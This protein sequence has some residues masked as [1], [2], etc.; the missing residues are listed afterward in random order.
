MRDMLRM[1]ADAVL[2]GE[3]PAGEG[4]DGRKGASG[5]PGGR[6]PFAPRKGDGRDAT[7]AADW[8]Q[9]PP[10]EAS[11]GGLGHGF[12]RGRRPGR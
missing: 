5:N 9:T 10:G 8:C 1:L 4:P 3:G 7:P 6:R 12:R 2:T 11:L